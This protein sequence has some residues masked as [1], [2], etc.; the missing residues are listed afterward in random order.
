MKN[1][2]NIL[3]A[4][5][6]LAACTKTEVTYDSPSE[7]A[8]SPVAENMTKAA[9]VNGAAPADQALLV[10]ANYAEVASSSSSSYSDAEVGDAYLVAKEFSSSDNKVWTNSDCFWPKSGAL[11]FAGCTKPSVGTVSYVYDDNKIQVSGFQQS[12]NTSESI[13]LMWFNKTTPANN[14][15]SED[16]EPLEIEMHHALAW[17][18]IKA[19]GGG[20]SKDWIITN[21]TMDNVVLGGDVLCTTDGAVWTISETTEET[22]DLTTND[23]AIYN[24]NQQVGTNPNMAVETTSNGTLLV[25]QKPKSISITYKTSSDGATTTKPLNLKLSDDPSNNKWEAGKHYIYTLFFNPYKI[26]FTVATENGVGGWTS[27]D[28]I[29]MQ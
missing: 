27:V 10:W 21:I 5:I 20:S 11:T 29:T 26:E 13:D 23:V 16:S 14:G 1:V 17:V 25:P 6:L 4:V 9:V 7:I 24:G 12:V 19:Y 22:K 3:A 15:L 8:F 2:I 18:T 28:P